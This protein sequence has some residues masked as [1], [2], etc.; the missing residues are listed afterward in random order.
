[1]WNMIVA[2]GFNTPNASIEWWMGE[3]Y[4]FVYE[5]MYGWIRERDEL[6]DS[7][8]VDGIAYFH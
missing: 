6:V 2:H 1:M 5:L 4:V 3:W 8:L 7:A